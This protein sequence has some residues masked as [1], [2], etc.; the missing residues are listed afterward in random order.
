MTVQQI[1]SWLILFRR[2]LLWAF[3]A[4]VFFTLFMHM[5]ITAEGPTDF[6]VFWHHFCGC[7]VDRDDLRVLLNFPIIYAVAGFILGLAPLQTASVQAV[8]PA[9][10]AETSFL[11]TK[12]VPRRTLL[13]APLALATAAIAVLPSLAI[14]LLFGWLR[15]VHAPSLHYLLVTVQQ[16][17][18]VA[19]L[20]QH[21]SFV[22][23]WSALQMTPRFAA[24]VTL[25][26]CAYTM[27]AS[28]RWLVL[29]PKKTLRLLG[30]LPPLLLCF[31]V[32]LFGGAVINYLLM[33]PEHDAVLGTVPSTSAILTHLAFAA[34]VIAGCWRLLSATEV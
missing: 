19:T 18:A 15:L 3:T 23:T 27:M 1:Q 31:P 26:L 14:T 34:A 6:G 13:L 21:P 9:Y 32:R 24:S 16:I 10:A 28:Q 20:G 17:P 25:G 7:P 12:P 2:R 11:L 8:S 33:T 5:W 4:S 29:S 22:A 30:V